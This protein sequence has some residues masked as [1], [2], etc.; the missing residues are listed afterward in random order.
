MAASWSKAVLSGEFEEKLAE[1]NWS[2]IVVRFGYA[3]EYGGGEKIVLSDELNV[4]CSERE[5]EFG[6]PSQPASSFTGCQFVD[7]G[8]GW[9]APGQGRLKLLQSWAVPG[10]WRTSSPGSR[11]DR[12]WPARRKDDGGVGRADVC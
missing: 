4:K 11:R 5:Q 2:S 9:Q 12:G 3:G 7:E 6:G 10:E 8:G 1:S